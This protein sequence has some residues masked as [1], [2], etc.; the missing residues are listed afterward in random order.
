MAAYQRCLQSWHDYF[1]PPRVLQHR[2]LK[3]PSPQCFFLRPSIL[4]TM[5]PF[6]PHSSFLP[7][8]SSRPPL[9]ASLRTSCRCL[10]VSPPSLATPL[11]ITAA[12][13]PPA[14]PQ[15][16]ASEPSSRVDRRRRQ[17]E[18]LRRGQELRLNA[19]GAGSKPLKPGQA[20]Q[21]RF[22]REVSVQR[23]ESTYTLRSQLSKPKVSTLHPHSLSFPF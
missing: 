8:R 7:P 6:H 15:P 19:G 23:D 9:L 10:H 4:L 12:G 2:N 5:P 21:R 1:R 3:L 14:A 20:L 11:P 18:L 16:A 13:P 22:W 17:A